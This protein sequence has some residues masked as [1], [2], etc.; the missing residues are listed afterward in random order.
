MWQVESKNETK[1]ESVAE[2]IR[3]NKFHW[4]GSVSLCILFDKCLF[5][6]IQNVLFSTVRNTLKRFI[7]AVCRYYH[8]AL[9]ILFA[10]WHFF[11]C[12]RCVL[13]LCNFSSI[14]RYRIRISEIMEE[15]KWHYDALELDLINHSLFN[16]IYT[17]L[18]ICVVWK[19]YSEEPKSRRGINVQSTK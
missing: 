6:I 9:L 3:N 11:F 19:E 7:D 16:C 15:G 14:I 10:W 13:R 1:K 5:Q 2:R 17:R 18:N 4:N 12:L 8:Y